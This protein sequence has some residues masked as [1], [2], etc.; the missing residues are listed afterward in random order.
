[1]YTQH[2]NHVVS[3]Y[4][5]SP[6]PGRPCACSRL[7][8]RDD[9]HTSLHLSLNW[10]QTGH[11]LKASKSCLGMLHVVCAGNVEQVRRKSP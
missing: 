2:V 10:Q 11:V 4:G 7:G 1:M 8:A 9:I 3:L 6:I 5:D